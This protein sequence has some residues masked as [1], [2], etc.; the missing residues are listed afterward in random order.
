MSFI[1]RTLTAIKPIT[2][3]SDL[4]TGFP[5]PSSPVFAVRVKA[6]EFLQRGLGKAKQK[7]YQGEIAISS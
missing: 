4:A 2:L 6:V 3:L 7:D 1:R 5:L